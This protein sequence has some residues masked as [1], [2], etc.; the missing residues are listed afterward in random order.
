MSSTPTYVASPNPGLAQI[1]NADAS[2]LKDLVTAGSSGTKV[3]GINVAST[4]TSARVIQ[5]WQTRSATA[6]LIGSLSVPAASGN[7]GSTISA[8]L[9]GL[10]GGLPVDNDGN[11]YI[12]LKS[13][14]KLQVSSTTTV[15]S[16]KI[17]HVT[18][19]AGDL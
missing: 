6:Y 19:T 11:P 12:L 13:G 16:A 10:I 9:L 15:T 14:D 2:S 8:N 17:V 1:A 18:A 3:T 4:D 7:D 5:L